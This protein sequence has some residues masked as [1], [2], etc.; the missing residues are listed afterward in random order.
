LSGAIKLLV[1]EALAVLRQE[2]KAALNFGFSPL[3]NSQDAHSQL[4]GAWWAYWS[5]KFFYH[6]GN[7]LYAFKNLAF[8]KTRWG[9]RLC[10]AGV[11]ALVFCLGCLPGSHF[12]VVQ[13]QVMAASGEHTC[14]LWHATPFSRTM[15]S[16]VDCC[17]CSCSTRR[18]PTL[19]ILYCC[20][21]LCRYGGGLVQGGAQ[22]RDPN[23]LMPPVYMATYSALPGLVLLDFFILIKYVGFYSGLLDVAVKLLRPQPSSAVCSS[24]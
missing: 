19:D 4:P 16:W 8:S 21:C 17:T 13:V 6:C 11:S 14:T 3:W 15:F 24:S 1:E 9:Q 23:V 7:N 20:V 5:G 18:H 22:F 12:A 2:G 10:P